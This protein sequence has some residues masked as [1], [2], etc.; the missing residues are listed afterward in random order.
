MG[1][2]MS[3]GEEMP[4][5]VGRSHVWRSPERWRHVI[6]WI[7]VTSPGLQ[8]C[9]HCAHITDEET[10][11]P[12]VAQLVSCRAAVEARPLTRVRQGG[13]GWTQAAGPCSAS[14]PPQ[15]LG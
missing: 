6:L 7:L 8:W 10:K 13:A 1:A 2:A 14:H 3:Q 15:N 12:T 5:L 9:C 11:A 4:A